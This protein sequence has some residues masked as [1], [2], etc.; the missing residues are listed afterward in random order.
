MLNTSIEREYIVVGRSDSTT[1]NGSAFSSL[2]LKYI[3][4]GNPSG[5]TPDKVE[6]LTLAIWDNTPGDP[7]KV[8]DIITLGEVQDRGGN[9]SVKKEGI[10]SCRSATESDCLY[11]LLPHP[12][13]LEEWNRC[14]DSLLGMCEASSLTEIVQEKSGSLYD[15]YCRFPAATNVHHAFKGGLATHTYQMLHLL[16]GLYPCLP[17][18]VHLDRCVLAILFHDYGKIAE[19]QED[20]KPTEDMYLLG[21]IFISSNYLNNLMRDKKIDTEVRK[22]VVHIILSHHGE[23]EYG[24]PVKPCTQEAVLVNMLDNMSA[25]SDTLDGTG[26][27][28]R[29][30]ALGTNVIKD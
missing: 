1:R 28:E 16:E 3:I 7:P 4:S 29:N 25:K 19:Y 26:N 15:R 10:L 21:H 6:E 23:L 24:S 14:L 27:M 2:K 30:F 20:G 22:R 13:G 17:Y 11:S 8:G 9:K 12:V 18:K 5:E